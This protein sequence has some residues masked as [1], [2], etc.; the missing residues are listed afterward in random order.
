MKVA[1]IGAGTS[2]LSCA[3]ELEKQGISPVIF[4]CNDF[5]GEYHSHV[6]AFLG[7]ITRPVADP[8]VYINRDLGIKLKPLNRFRKVI[9]YSPNN[10]T[11]VSG[12]LGYFMIR[13]REEISVKNQLYAQIKSHVHFGS[14][15]QPEDLENEFDHIVVADG[16]W[17]IPARYGIWQEMMRTWLKGGIFEGDFED[18]TLHMWLDKELTNGAYIYLA[19]YSKN[20]A[21]IAQIV[22]N[23]EHAELNDYWYRFLSSRDILKKYN[24]LET[25]ELPHHAGSVTT[26][27]LNK[28]YFIGASGGG[29]EPFLG[30]GQFNA[31]VAGVMAAKSIATGA[32]MNFLMKDLTKKGQ[33][34]ADFRSLMNSATNKDFDHLLTFMKTPGLRSLIYKTDINILDILAKGLSFMPSRNKGDILQSRGGK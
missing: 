9:H 23:I 32:D 22:Q 28:M 12:P 20:K 13:G 27:K 19:P 16:Q 34:M 31:I 17:T 7:L 8:I 26:N 10:Q 21:V 3:I 15:V 5:I 2:G 33:Q 14:F 11:V 25:W 30:F 6:S 18:D 1:I 24:L 29:A 4:E